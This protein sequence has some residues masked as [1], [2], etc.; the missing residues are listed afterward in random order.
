MSGGHRTRATGRSHHDALM[1]VGHHDLVRVVAGSAATA[2]AGGREA[3]GVDAS[4]ERALPALAQSAEP[5]IAI[6][7]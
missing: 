1:A 3:H 4:G 7:T 5:L 6:T 2:G